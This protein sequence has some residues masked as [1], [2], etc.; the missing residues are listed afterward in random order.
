L[1]PH[2]YALH[3]RAAAPRAWLSQSRPGIGLTLRQSWRAI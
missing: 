1:R 3:P 2:H